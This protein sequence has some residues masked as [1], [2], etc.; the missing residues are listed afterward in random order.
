MNAQGR[1][2]LIFYGGCT[3]E[4]AD[5]GGGTFIKTRLL[6]EK[7]YGVESMISGSKNIISKLH[8]GIWVYLQ[9]L[10]II[11]RPNHFS[12]SVLEINDHVYLF[13]TIYF[14]YLLFQ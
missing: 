2:Y 9:L 11:R 4:F 7:Q 14:I 8:V 3:Q 12:D 13:P 10:Y 5:G 6:I 1:R